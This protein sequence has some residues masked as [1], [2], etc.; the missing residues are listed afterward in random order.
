MAK[1][2]ISLNCGLNSSLIHYKCWGYDRV[3][4]LIEFLALKRVWLTLYNEDYI[5]LELQSVYTKRAFYKE[6]IWLFVSKFNY[7]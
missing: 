3:R 1:I 4:D 2:E 7:N 5:Q 6:F